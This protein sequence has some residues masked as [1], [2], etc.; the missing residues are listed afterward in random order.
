MFDRI[1]TCTKS[2]S[3]YLQ[4]AQVNL[5]RAADLVS[6]TVSTLELFC[7]DEEWDK[8][9]CYA[10]SVAEVKHIDITNPRPPRQRQLPQHFQDCI[11]LAPT[12][13]WEALSTSQQYKV[14]L[15]FPAIDT[16]LA[17]LNC[18]FSQENIEIMRAI[19]T[20]SPDSEHFLDPTQLK[21]IAL[22]YNLD[23][24]LL[25]MELT[26]A[27]RTLVKA[28]MENVGDVFLELTPLRAAFPT[29]LK[30][31]HIALTISVSTAQCERSFSALK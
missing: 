7:T 2:L 4:H 16:F 3:D 22:D 13:T 26:L 5:V 8:L 25:S 31:I 6:A 24:E 28:E 29:L 18:H 19:H 30:A 1:L 27:K 17:E 14:N 12:G 15:Y 9:F 10:Q 23:Y 20:F 21:P 11:V